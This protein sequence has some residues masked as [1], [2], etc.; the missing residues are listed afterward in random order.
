[1]GKVV[2]ERELAVTD[3]FEDLKDGFVLHSLCEVRAGT[4][5]RTEMDRGFARPLPRAPPHAPS[6]RPVVPP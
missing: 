1:V 6:L 5:Q 4:R 2:A 3:L